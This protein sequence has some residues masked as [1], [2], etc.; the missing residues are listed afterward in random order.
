VVIPAFIVN[1]VRRR[2]PEGSTEL[3]NGPLRGRNA[4]S[5]ASC[6]RNNEPQKPVILS[7]V[8]PVSA[9]R[10][11]RTCVSGCSPVGRNVE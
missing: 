10:S 6:S 2:T 7:E 9:K 1:A 4:T 3:S 11:R 8:W 5:I